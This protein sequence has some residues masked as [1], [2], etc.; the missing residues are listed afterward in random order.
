MIPTDTKVI[1]LRNFDDDPPPPLFAAEAAAE[2]V[3]VDESLRAPDALGEEEDS[4]VF[5]D[6]V[7]AATDSSILFF[8]DFTDSPFE[9]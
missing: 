2:M 4:V 9:K 3:G 6:G 7:V 1:P 5:S 8:Q